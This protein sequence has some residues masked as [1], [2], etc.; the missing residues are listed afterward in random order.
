MVAAPK[1]QRQSEEG[2]RKK[3]KNSY[4][5]ILGAIGQSGY[6]FPGRSCSIKGL[7]RDDDSMCITL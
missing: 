1:A 2:K 4:R 7:S 5:Q 6:D 3:R